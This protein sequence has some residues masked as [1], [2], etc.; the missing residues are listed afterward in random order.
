M[1]GDAPEPPD[2]GPLAEVNEALGRESLDFMRDQWKFSKRQARDLMKTVNRVVDRSLKTQEAEAKFAESERKRY[3]EEY[4]PRE[5]EFAEEADRFDSPERREREAGRAISEVSQSYSAGRKAAEQRLAGYGIDPSMLRAGALDLSSRIEEAEAKAGAGTM[6]RQRVEDVGRAMR[7]D[8]VN[9]GRG[10]PLQ[11]TQAYGTSLQG[12]GLAGGTAATGAGTAANI[13]TS[14]AVYGNQALSGYAGSAQALNLG[15]QN[16]L[17]G[18]EVGQA[19]GPAGL[20][21]GAASTAGGVAAGR[22][23]FDDGGQ[24]EKGMSPSR[25]AIPDDVPAKLSAGEHVIPKDVVAWKGEEFFHRLTEKVR[26]QRK[27]AIPEAA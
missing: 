8:V 26:E 20:L 10:V 1:C 7:A 12:G 6:A 23:G 9:M 19:Y 21:L 5:R 25:G 18:Y 14:P 15:Y 17:A 22:F 16:A 27:A 3:Q 24:V 2:Y 11:A 4:I 13:R